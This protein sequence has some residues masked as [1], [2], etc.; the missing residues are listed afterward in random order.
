MY[1]CASVASEG[2][3]SLPHSLAKRVRIVR[4]LGE[5]T[6]FRN[7]QIY[8]ELHSISSDIYMASNQGLGTGSKVPRLPVD[9]PRARCILHCH[10]IS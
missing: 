4:L 6:E 7:N 10:V 5:K 3:G 9:L 1:D 2:R 8:S